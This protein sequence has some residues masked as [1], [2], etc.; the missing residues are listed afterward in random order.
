MKAQKRHE[1]TY[2][3]P[4]LAVGGGPGK[5]TE[6]K[7]QDELQRGSKQEAFENLLKDKSTSLWCWLWFM[8]LNRGVAVPQHQRQACIGCRT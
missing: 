7:Q 1:R 5:V 6:E 8:E 2:E 3:D 4:G